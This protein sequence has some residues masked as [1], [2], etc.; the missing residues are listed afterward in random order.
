ML[1]L[2]LF[3]DYLNI[4]SFSYFQLTWTGRGFLSPIRCWAIHLV[5]CDILSCWGVYSLIIWFFNSWRHEMNQ[6]LLNRLRVTWLFLHC[7]KGRNCRLV[8]SFADWSCLMLFFKEHVRNI[9]FCNDW[10]S[11]YLTPHVKE[12]SILFGY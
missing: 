8:I 1:K 2:A 4:V 10:C 12:Q 9:L 7:A 3:N 5:S 11:T 6:V